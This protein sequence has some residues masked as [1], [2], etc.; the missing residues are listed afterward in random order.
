MSAWL[1]HLIGDK[2]PP[3]LEVT[4]RC[5]PH[6]GNDRYSWGLSSSSSLSVEFSTQDEAVYVARSAPQ[7]PQCYV[8]GCYL[9]TD[10]RYRPTDIMN[11]WGTVQYKMV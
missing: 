6:T 7:G 2:A 8:E 3:A 4:P 10:L 9:N 5:Y 11:S 1:L